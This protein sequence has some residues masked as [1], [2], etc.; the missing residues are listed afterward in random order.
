MPTD[1]AV[2]D[3]AAWA[4]RE[5]VE[6]DRLR[7]IFTCCHPALSADA[8]VALTLRE[9]CGLST[10]EIARAFL[11]PGSDPGAAH[12]PREGQDSRRADSLSGAD[13]AG[14]ARSP[15]RGAAGDL[16][17]LQRGLRGVLRIVADAARSCRPR[18]SAWA[19]CWSSCCPSR[20]R[21]ACSR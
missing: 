3:P 14:A 5:S 12:R 19:A 7:L 8:Q 1:L 18:R 13:A 11:T 21:W 6:D 15:R 20:K 16:P 2:D 4:D 9:V 10:E 17:G